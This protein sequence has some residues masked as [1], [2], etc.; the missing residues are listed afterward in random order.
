MTDRI[1][2]RNHSTKENSQGFT[3]LEVILALLIIGIFFGVVLG[4][5]TEQWRSHQAIKEKME[6]HYAAM[7]AG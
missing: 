6:A 7:V 3:L 1:Q 4:F 2:L 5:F